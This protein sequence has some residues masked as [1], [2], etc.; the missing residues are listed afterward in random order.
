[1]HLYATIF[2]QDAAACVL[3]ADTMA[4]GNTEHFSH[5]VCMAKFEY[6]K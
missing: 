5:V 3:A 4:K 2:L 6:C 1:M